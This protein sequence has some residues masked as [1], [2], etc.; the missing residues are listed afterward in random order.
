MFLLKYIIYSFIFILIL[1]SL[2]MYCSRNGSIAE[3]VPVKQINEYKTSGN[4]LGYFE[5]K[6][7][8]SILNL[9]GSYYEM[10][11]QYGSLASNQLNKIYRDLVPE[12]FEG[13]NFR[14]FISYALRW[15]YVFQMDTREKEL[16]A[17]MSKTSGL[18]ERQLLSIEMLPT[19]TTLYSGMNGDK[20]NVANIHGNGFC[21]FLSV[22]G[23]L[24]K[25]GNMMVA[26]NLDLSTPVTK[27]DDY[28]SLVIYN[29]D[30][31]DNSVANFGFL[32]F[33]PGFTWINNKGLFSEYNDGRRSVPGFN[34][35][36]Q[37][38]LN[39]AFYGMLSSSSEEQYINY[40][41]NH[42]AFV[43]N[44]TAI[45]SSEKSYSIEHAVNS[46]PAVLTGQLE[47]ANYFTNLYRTNFD[48]AKIT[49]DNCIEV[50]KDTPSYACVRYHHI[51]QFLNKTNN[52]DVNHLKDFFSTSLDDGGVYQ[53]GASY[54]YPVAEVTIYTIVGDMSLM[55][56]MYSNHKDSNLWVNLNLNDYFKKNN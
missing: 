45:V 53:T 33:I 22:W 48:K 3:Y 4:N 27:L 42:P 2:F 36:G 24:S 8:L 43:S 46:E 47:S 31:G 39:T 5:K 38:G 25:S 54:K 40:I 50:T 11:M 17:G 34:V 23:N 21:S 32:G 13:F 26:R 52:L 51:T 1:L 10:G 44:F 30:N 35:F 29:P 6:D 15:Y 19:L 9:H 14:T 16:L 7:T 55:N 18:S 41:K 20:L 12:Y 28:Y 49:M 56:F 37:I